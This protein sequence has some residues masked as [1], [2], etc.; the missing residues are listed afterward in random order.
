MLAA[1][2]GGAAETAA[3]EELLSGGSEGALA[4]RGEATGA[5]PTANTRRWRHGRLQ[6]PSGPASGRHLWTLT[7]LVVAVAV[8]Y[9]INVNITHEMVPR[10]LARSS[11][12]LGQ[13]LPPPPSSS[14]YTVLIVAA[15]WAPSAQGA[16]GSVPVGMSMLVPFIIMGVIEIGRGVG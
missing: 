3:K 6:S 5:R 8:G 14:T 11:G 10:S 1:A 9:S 7:T 4:S 13:Q 2:A 15:P 16:E 12:K